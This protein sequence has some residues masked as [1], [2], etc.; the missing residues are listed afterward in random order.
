MKMPRDDMNSSISTPES[1]LHSFWR[2][3]RLCFFRVRTI[4]LFE[5]RS[6]LRLVR[7]WTFAITLT[8]LSIG[9][10]LL[11]CSMAS[12]IAPNSTTM[13]ITAPLYVLGDIDP[14]Y[15]LIVQLGALFLLFDFRHR[16]ERHRIAEVLDARPVSNL[17]YVL[18]RTIGI[19]SPLWLTVCGIVALMQLCGFVSVVS[20]FYYLKTFQIHSVLSLVLLD[21]TVLLLAWCS[22]TIFLSTLVRSRLW[23]ICIA[24]SL[25]LAWLYISS[26]AP[27][28]FLHILSPLSNATVLVSDIDPEIASWNTI[29]IRSSTVFGSLAFVLMSGLFWTRNDDVPR[30]RKIALSTSALVVCSVFAVY[31]TVANVQHFDQAAKWKNVHANYKWRGSVDVQSIT[32]HVHI[33][34]RQNLEIAVSTQLTVIDPATETLVFTFNPAMTIQDLTLNNLATPFA[35]QDGLLEVPLTKAAD[36]RSSHTL[37]VE[38]HGRPD[39]RFGYFANVVD[40]VTKSEWP[41]RAVRLFGKDVSVYNANYVAL[42]PESYWYPVPGPVHGGYDAEQ[43]ATDFFDVDLQVSLNPQNWMLVGTGTAVQ[44]LEDG[45]TYRVNPANSVHEIGLFAS[46]FEQWSVEVDGISFELYLHHRH[47]RNMSMHDGTRNELLLHVQDRLHRFTEHG[48]TL[49][50]QELYLVEVPSRLRTIGGGWRMDSASILPGIVLIKEYGFPTTQFNFPLNRLKSF[51]NEQQF[52]KAR[53]SLLSRHFQ[54]GVGTDNPWTNLPEL[55][56]S[57]ATTAKGEH[58]VVLDQVILALISHLGDVPAAFFNVYATFE[59][60]EFTHVN[61]HLAGL[62]FA[63][64]GY[65]WSYKRPIFSLRNMEETHGSRN[66]IWSFSESSGLTD[67]PS[68]GGHQYDLELLL[69]KSNQIA[70]GLLAANE[71]EDV[72]RW[73]SDVRRKHFGTSYSYQDLIAAAKD[74]GVVVEPFLTKWL[75]TASLPGFVASLVN[76]RRIADD[77]FGYNQ[78]QATIEIRNTQPISGVV[79]LRYP[80]STTWQSFDDFALTRG[81]IVPG[82]SAKRINPIVSYPMETVMVIPHLSLN[83]EYF[84]TSRPTETITG[85]LDAMQLPFE[86][87]SNWSP[88]QHGIVVDDLDPGFIV[89]QT[90]SDWT[91]ADFKHVGPFGW[92][93]AAS[94]EVELDKGL[95]LYESRGQIINASGIWQRFSELGA[96]GVYRKTFAV[97]DIRKRFQSARFVAHLPESGEWT[98]D[99]HIPARWLASSSPDLRYVFEISDDHSSW[100]AELAIG[101][102]VRGWN[103]VGLFQ[104]QKGDVTVELVGTSPPD[105]MYADAIRWT[106][107]NQP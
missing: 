44:V 81:V 92:N 16:M 17:E 102:T 5:A 62:G 74:K 42:M 101:E 30:L 29:G 106:R 22:L 52:Q 53:V 55:I 98:L 72:Y 31:S 68:S 13:G 27:F 48:L 7:F 49:P 87:Q 60:A 93:Q 35:F 43:T 25:M 46:E 1:W 67:I 99:Y 66:S 28:S 38:A 39:P 75:E 18:G 97:A 100:S 40:F 50:H 15:F 24:M 63:S 79:Q 26:N 21:A 19:A 14:T 37:R 104:V 45:A 107:V 70:Q 71:E 23:V 58:S 96:Y 64:A 82:N 83:R 84:L 41:I 78:Y 6:S 94:L 103:L 59:I 8:S 80:Q 91:F 51:M 12:Y 57:H 34:P 86:E 105:G 90:R 33:N 9:G 76:T 88:R 61:E 11:S 95:P 56:W 73:L 89:E 10:Y 69:F 54:S 32:G 2:S 3:A 47:S 65:D 4:A 36:G 85:E 77:E 20:G